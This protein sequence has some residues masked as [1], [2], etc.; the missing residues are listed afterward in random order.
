M[1]KLTFSWPMYGDEARPSSKDIERLLEHNVVFQLDFLKDVVFEAQK[2]Y[3]EALQRS[4]EQFEEA[5]KRRMERSNGSS[6][7]H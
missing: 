4:R 2:L 7:A 1:A 3:E 5:R 6:A